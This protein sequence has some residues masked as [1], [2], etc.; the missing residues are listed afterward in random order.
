[1]SRKAKRTLFA[2]LLCLYVLTWVLGHGPVRDSI[3]A[4]EKHYGTL[5]MK[6]FPVLP[7]VLLCS[8]NNLSELGGRTA[9]G[10]YFWYGFGVHTIV[11]VPIVIA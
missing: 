8:S 3:D 6:S 11:E 9:I 4:N 5:K 7:C 2:I 10:L 1:M